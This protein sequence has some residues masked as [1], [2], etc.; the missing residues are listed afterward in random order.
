MHQRAMTRFQVQYCIDFILVNLTRG[1]TVCVYAMDPAGLKA[2]LI[3]PLN[4]GNK[5]DFNS[6]SS[7]TTVVSSI[8][9]LTMQNLPT[10]TLL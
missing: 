5:R 2:P 4:Y 9:S 3:L 10:K 8:P 6:I 7:N 1:C